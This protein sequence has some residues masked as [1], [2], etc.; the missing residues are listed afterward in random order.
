MVW[1]TSKV[2][3]PPAVPGKVPSWSVSVL[4]A[5]TDQAA[6]DWRPQV[7]SLQASEVPSAGQLAGLLSGHAASLLSIVVPPQVEKTAVPSSVAVQSNQTSFVI[8][9][10]PN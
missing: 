10:V 4:P 8:P 5:V 9:L 7:S 3:D 2:P 1:L 6:L